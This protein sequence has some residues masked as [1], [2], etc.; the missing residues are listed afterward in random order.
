M[1]CFLLSAKS[2]CL[3]SKQ[4]PFKSQHSQVPSYN[5]LCV[6]ARP[7][8]RNTIGK[9]PIKLAAIFVLQLVF[10]TSPCSISVRLFVLCCCFFFFPAHLSS[11]CSLVSSLISYDFF[12][13][14]LIST[15]AFRKPL[16]SVFICLPESC[17][18]NP[19]VL[20]ELH[21]SFILLFLLLP[22]WIDA[23]RT[24]PVPENAF[25]LHCKGEPCLK[26]SSF[27]WKQNRTLYF[28]LTLLNSC[29]IHRHFFL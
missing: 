15:W 11:N 9:R 21:Q 3:Q 24:V 19:V 5:F 22:P 7:V 27:S 8:I 17:S 6:N 2:A 4:F 18:T 20:F 23:S 25:C 13:I 14:T 1:K 29:K 16:C 26:S 10:L 28:D 12:V